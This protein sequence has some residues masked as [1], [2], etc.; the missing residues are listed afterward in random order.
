MRLRTFRITPPSSTL[1]MNLPRVR[2]LFVFEY[3][4]FHSTSRYLLSQTTYR[5][6]F[7]NNLTT[8]TAQQTISTRG[9]RPMKSSAVFCTQ[10]TI[11]D[12]FHA[13]T[14]TPQTT[15]PLYQKHRPD[16]TLRS[17]LML[18]Q[19]TVCMCTTDYS[20]YVYFKVMWLFSVA[21]FCSCM[22]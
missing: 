2:T 19:T 15:D 9:V 17:Y 1:V 13:V 5:Y 10:Y 14:P 11:H 6:A 12:I 20:L 4:I 8:S 16:N 7:C 21:V 22:F 3:L 18:L